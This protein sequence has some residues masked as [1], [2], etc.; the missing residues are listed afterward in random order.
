MAHFGKDVDNFSATRTIHI[1]GVETNEKF[2][3][4]QRSFLSPISI[5]LAV[6]K[7]CT[8]MY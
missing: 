2:T 5:T 3:V 4:G 8:C 1:V 7:I 6:K